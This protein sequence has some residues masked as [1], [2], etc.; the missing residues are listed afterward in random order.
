MKPIKQIDR[1]WANAKN[2]LE[3]IWTI[4]RFKHSWRINSN[5]VKTGGI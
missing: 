5:N 2:L 3:T 1:I 4:S